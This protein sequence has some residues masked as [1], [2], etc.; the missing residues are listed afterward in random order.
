MQG[1]FDT[2]INLLLMLT[3]YHAK[4]GD[5]WNVTPGQIIRTNKQLYHIFADFV[6]DN[7]S[8]TALIGDISLLNAPNFHPLDRGWWV[9]PDLW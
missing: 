7:L 8:R 5:C 1:G 6:R 2:P 9:M 3:C 4:F